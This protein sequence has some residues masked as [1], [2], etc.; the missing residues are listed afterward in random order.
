MKIPNSSGVVRAQSKSGNKFEE[1][2]ALTLEQA[3]QLD[4]GLR[5]GGERPLGAL[6]GGAQAAQR[7]RAGAQVLLVLA[8]ELLRAVSS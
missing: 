8:L 2:A 5:R 4:E 7:A 1:K 6:A 3:V